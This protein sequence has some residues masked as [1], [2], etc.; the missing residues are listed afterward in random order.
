MCFVMTCYW[1]PFHMLEVGYH[2]DEK[3]KCVIILA[4]PENFYLKF[5]GNFSLNY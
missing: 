1:A 2:M 4:E 5:S 3:N